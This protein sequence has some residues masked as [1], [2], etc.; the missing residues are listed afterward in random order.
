M[1]FNPKW[2][3]DSGHTIEITST[4]MYCVTCDIFLTD[5]TFADS[6]AQVARQEEAAVETEWEAFK[7]AHGPFTIEKAGPGDEGYA[8][9]DRII[10][11]Q[12]EGS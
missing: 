8:P 2:H 11:E 7:A 6:K 1:N 9:P 10:A 4:P 12:E 3:V 5:D